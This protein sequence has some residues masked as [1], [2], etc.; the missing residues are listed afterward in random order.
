[1]ATTLYSDT[2]SSP[3]HALDQ[4]TISPGLL[5]LHPRHS[6]N[7]CT[8]FLFSIPSGC[9]A[10]VTKHGANVE[11]CKNGQKSIVWPAGLHWGMPW[12]KISHLVTCQTVVLDLPVK[13]C[14][15]K[16]NVTVNIDVALAFRIMGDAD[17]GEDPDLVRKFVYELKPRGLEQQLRDAQDEAVRGL[18][19]SLLHTEI[20]GIRSGVSTK[21]M[22]DVLGSVVAAEPP[23]VVKEGHRDET[24]VGESDEGDRSH[25]TKATAEG[26]DV[27]EYMKERLNKQFMPQGVQILSIMIQSCTLP[28]DIEEQMSEKTKVISKNAQQ[29]MFHQNNM[30]NTRMSE[31]IT[32]LQQ[33][34]EEAR[35]QEISSGKE[36]INEEKV[37]FDD[38]KAEAVKSEAAIV[39]EGVAR[40]EKLRAESALEVSR[41]V[42]RKVSAVCYGLVL[43]Y[44]CFLIV[45]LTTTQQS[46]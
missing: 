24:L 3:S 6:R 33:T 15:T 30:Q 17:Q 10:L 31:E 4:F 43:S 20:Y 44:P 40:I 42:N 2:T 12:V 21:K 39:E 14:K 32:T 25:A 41:V 8:P 37:K 13:A 28:Q 34:F 11:Y 27:T 9:Y 22:K 5:L 18:A 35:T 23:V 1:M 7:L 16:D 36:M 26:M 38:A 29:R 45:S 19:R 46:G